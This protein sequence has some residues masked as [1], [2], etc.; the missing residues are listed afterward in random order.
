MRSDVEARVERGQLLLGS[1]NTVRAQTERIKSVLN[2][3]VL[4]LHFPDLD[5]DSIMHALDLFGTRVLPRL[6]QC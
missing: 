2:P 4:D 3:G 1:P 6:Q 5:R